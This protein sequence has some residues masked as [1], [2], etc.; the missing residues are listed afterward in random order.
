MKILVN[1]RTATVWLAC[2]GFLSPTSVF[3]VQPE[4]TPTTQSQAGVRDVALNQGNVL[5]GTLMNGQ[6]QRMANA[7]VTVLS[8]DVPVATTVTSST[9]EFSVAGLRGGVYQVNAGTTGGVFRL[10]GPQTAPPA[11]TAG[12][13]LVDNQSLV[14]RGQCGPACETGGGYVEGPM[15]Y[16]DPGACGPACDDGCCP[17]PC[18]G[19]GCAGG[20]MLGILS[21]PWFIGAA[22]AA[23][24][25]I[26]LAVDDDDAS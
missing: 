1:L 5:H 21:N 23:A 26:P 16:G 9:G 14:T 12:L 17:D 10:W 8:G 15:M 13:L 11:A 3:G 4:V 18:G 25:A 22:V 7:T 19:G 20:G 24:I 6:G 2:I